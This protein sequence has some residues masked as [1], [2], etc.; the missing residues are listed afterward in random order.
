VP[1]KKTVI[2][3]GSDH[4]HVQDEPKLAKTPNHVQRILWK[5]QAHRSG[6]EQTKD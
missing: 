1:A 4:E 2:Q 5:H 3:L 6:Q